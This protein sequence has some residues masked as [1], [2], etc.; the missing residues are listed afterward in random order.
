MQPNRPTLTPPWMPVGLSTLVLLGLVV[1]LNQ[2]APT[3]LL[4]RQASGVQPSSVTV[5]SIH[6][7]TKIEWQQRPSP[8]TTTSTPTSSAGK[9]PNISASPDTGLVASGTVS[10]EIWN[11]DLVPVINGA[12]YVVSMNPLGSLRLECASGSSEVS[13][14]FSVPLNAN[15]CVLQIT[16][17]A[18]TPWSVRR[19]A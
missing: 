2:R 3:P 1:V 14:Q 5:T 8:V 7:I 9:W 4:S 19:T 6:L 11:Q 16:G 13:L 10:Q 18:G 12:A 15:S 17:A